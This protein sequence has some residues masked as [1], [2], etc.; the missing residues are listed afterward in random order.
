MKKIILKVTAV[1]FA[2]AVAGS[3][4][5]G[6]SGGGCGGTP[7]PA[8]TAQV[9]CGQGTYQVNGQCVADPGSSGSGTGTTASGANVQ[10]TPSGA[11]QA[12]HH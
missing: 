12:I 10:A 3:L 8:T 7:T 11:P 5:C 1:W 6:S 4:G 9:T 2:C